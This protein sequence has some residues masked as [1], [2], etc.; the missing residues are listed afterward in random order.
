[1]T[2]ETARIKAK[3]LVAA[4][5]LEEKASQMLYTAPAL[6]RVGLPEYNWWNE[7]LHGVARAGLSTVFPQSIALSATFNREILHK[8]GQVVGEEGR[9]K[10]VIY[11]SEGDRGI[12]KGLTF[13][14][15]NVN[16]V[17]DPRWG[18]G[19][20]SYGEDPFLN[21]EMGTE[22]VKG[23]QQYADPTKEGLQA[24]ACVKH[25]AAHSGPEGIRHGFNSEVTEKELRETYLPAFERIVKDAD[26]AGVMSSYNAVNGVPTSASKVLLRDILRDEWGFE[27]YTV[28]DCGAI[29]DIYSNHHY[30]DTKTEAAAAAVE[31]G[32]NLNC[33][34]MYAYVLEAVQKGIL[35]ESYVDDAVENLMTIRLLLDMDAPEVDVNAAIS[36]WIEK[37]KEWQ[38]DNQKAAE[39]CVVL[40]KNNG[41]LPLKETPKTIAIVGPDAKSLTVLE[42]NYHGT[43]AEMMTVSQG[44]RE[45][46]KGADYLYSEGAHLYKEKVEACSP[47]PDDRCS[48]AAA[49]ACYA[50]VTFAVVG[51][52]PS[53]EGEAGDASNEYAAG[54]KHDLHIP[55]SQQKMLEAVCAASDNVVVILMSGGALDL[56]DMNDKVAAIVQGWYPG[57]EG[58]KAIAGVISGRINPT[59]RLPLTFYHNEQVTWDFCDYHTKGKTYRFFDGEP[60][61]SFGY[62][63]GYDYLTIEK[64]ERKDHTVCV[65]LKNEHDHAVAMPVEVYVKAEEE[66]LETP[67]FQ[68]VGFDKP[69]LA[70]GEEKTIS[71][72]LNPYWLQV[73]EENGTRRDCKGTLTFY[74]ADH[75]PDQR[76]EAICCQKAIVL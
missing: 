74:V 68:L 1:M 49:Y 60:L 34:N 72:E 41:I 32:C 35:D 24:A 16:I 33:G 45:E 22:F 57:S 36:E 5:T 2:K 29:A 48:E 76:S 23:I 39:E 46:F 51:L 62:G 65:T 38:K 7:A 44:L 50:D 75:L 11:R 70:G 6:E 15:P 10:N 58:G 43:A 64:A 71:M 42:G 13:W 27:G 19:H 8:V 69:C 30:T 25:F 14:S 73:V 63:L 54:D 53:I 52:D 18:R 40:L 47:T 17:R 20:E 28:S 21:A 55:V 31:G 67:N 56:G 26:A 4:M 3:E 66:G 37:Q 61:Y 9:L 12:Y 59:G